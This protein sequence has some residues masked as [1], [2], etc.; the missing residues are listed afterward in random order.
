MTEAFEAAHEA[1]QSL[2]SAME[3]ILWQTA[4]SERCISLLKENRRLSRELAFAP[5]YGPL[6]DFLEVDESLLLEELDSLLREL[7]SRA[8]ANAKGLRA[9]L[10]ELYR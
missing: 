7:D 9:K 6:L 2:R 3:R 4:E 10:G 8:P 5:G 1:A